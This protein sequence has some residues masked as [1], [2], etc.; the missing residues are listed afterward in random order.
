MKTICVLVIQEV[1]CFVGGIWQQTC[2]Q[3]VDPENCTDAEL[4]AQAEWQANKDNFAALKVKASR[5]EDWLI[6][7]T[8]QN[9]IDEN[10]G[11]RVT[12]D[13]RFGRAF[14][15]DSARILKPDPPGWFLSKKDLLFANGYLIRG[16]TVAVEENEI[17]SIKVHQDFLNRNYAFAVVGA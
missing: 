16:W 15:F 17:V 5:A 14:W 8:W 7:G 1:G 10:K 12:K 11:V 4:S 6:D 9:I 3:C 13:G 2:P